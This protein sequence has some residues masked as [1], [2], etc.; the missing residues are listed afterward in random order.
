MSEN[1]MSE[2]AESPTTSRRSL[3]KTS[4]L[5]AAGAAFMAACSPDHQKVGVSGEPAVPTSNPPTLPDAEPT[6]AVIA[7]NQSQ[8]HTL[9]SVEALVAEVYGKNAAAI[10]DGQLREAAVRF[11][12]DHE[13][14]A[15]AIAAATIDKVAPPANEELRTAMVA[16]MQGLLNTQE[17]VL[18]FLADLESTLAATY[19][20]AAGVLTVA[21]D[22][23]LVM[24]YGAACARRVTV[25]GHGGE[26][27][28][29]KTARFPTDDLIP[30]AAYLDLA[31]EEGD[32]PEG[33]SAE[34]EADN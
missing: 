28:M 33:D 1:V 17:H 27:E 19:I 13:T 7:A 6:A 22:R 16:P 2:H 20:T 24:T 23:Q 31:A 29:P 18:S 12:Q 11:G 30:G 8:L 21:S 9:A 25:L 3:L 5:V 34:A 15:K 26:G 10:T 14:A 32:S 4:G